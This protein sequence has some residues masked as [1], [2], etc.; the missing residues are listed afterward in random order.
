VAGFSTGK[1]FPDVAGRHSL[2]MKRSVFT[3]P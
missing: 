2:L 1:R 3:S